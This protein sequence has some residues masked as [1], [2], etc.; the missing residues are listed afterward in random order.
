M[1]VA[2][3]NETRTDQAQLSGNAIAA[4]GFPEKQIIASCSVRSRALLSAVLLPFSERECVELLYSKH[5]AAHSVLLERFVIA[6]FAR[7]VFMLAIDV[8][9]W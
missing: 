8:T 1:L 5:N 4:K 6:C 2:R 3:H 7:V 9:S